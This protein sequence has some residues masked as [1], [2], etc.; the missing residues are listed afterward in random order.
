MGIVLL[1]PPVAIDPAEGLVW[2]NGI[3]TESFSRPG[4]HN[5]LGVPHL[6]STSV[7]GE[8]MG[9]YSN[10]SPREA[11]TV[12]INPFSALHHIIRFMAAEWVNVSHTVE[13]EL[14]QLDYAQA[15]SIPRFQSLQQELDVLH[16]WRRRCAK[17][18]ETL[19]H[20]EKLCRERG[21]LPWPKGSVDNVDLLIEDFQSLIQGFRRMERQAEK[22]I[23]TALGKISVEVGEKSVEEARRV[24]RLST[25]ASIFLPLSFVAT[26]FS[27]NGR[28]ALDADHGWI[29]LAVASPLLICIT[30]CGLC[31]RKKPQH[32]PAWNLRHDHFDTEH[33]RHLGLS[34]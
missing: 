10:L 22:Q 3:H 9:Y 6:P 29:Y 19:R 8:V 20:S 33:L 2:Q 13:C 28:F 4:L 30:L 26:I 7:Y 34:Y 32:I 5:Y 31:F 16:M 11:Q 21:P 14:T 23:C 15:N 25:I 18:V 24:T 12:R 27:M 17:Y 1:D